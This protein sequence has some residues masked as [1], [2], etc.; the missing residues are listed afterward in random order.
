M[1]E[2]NCEEIGKRICERRKAKGLTQDKVSEK[3]GIGASHFGQIERGDNKCSLRVMTNIAIVLESSLDNLV[4]GVD[5]QNA[6]T[7]L[8]EVFKEVPKDKRAKFVKMCA[9]LVDILK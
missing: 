5:E 9:C 1:Y 3:V 4:R 8:M 6:D 2:L 7:E